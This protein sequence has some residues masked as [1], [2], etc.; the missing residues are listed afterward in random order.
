MAERRPWRCPEC[1]GIVAPHV[2]VHWCG[3]KP[4]GGV[5]VRRPAVPKSPF[6]GASLTT[7][8]PPGAVLTT[9]TG[10]AYAIGAG[11]GDGG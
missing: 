9:N 5:T 3:G 6:T 2:D 4:D 8:L 10:A 7:T 1:G 11:G